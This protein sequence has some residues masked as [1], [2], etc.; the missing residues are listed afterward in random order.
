MGP[1]GGVPVMSVAFSLRTAARP[2]NALAGLPMS[3]RQA[4]QGTRGP[5]DVIRS[6]RAVGAAPRGRERH[7]P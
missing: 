7:S 6:G 2:L 4:S 1:G 5:C 3:A